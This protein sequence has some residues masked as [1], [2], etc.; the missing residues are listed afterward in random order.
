MPEFVLC[1]HPDL[2][3]GQTALMA[4]PRN[5]WHPVEGDL[6]SPQGDE[7]GSPNAGESDT[8]E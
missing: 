7:D 3:W 5:G 6:S 8:T 4:N 1:E 2:P